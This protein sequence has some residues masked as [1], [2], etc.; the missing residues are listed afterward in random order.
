MKLTAD[1][2]IV[3]GGV[4]GCS[5][6]YNLAARGMKDLVLLERDVLGSGST[7]RSQ[8]I[9]RMHYSNA[10]TARMAWQSLDVYRNFDEIVGGPSGFVRTGYLVV[11]GPEDRKALEDNVSMQIALGIKTAVVSPADVEEIA[12]ML[13]VKDAGGLAYEPESGYADPYRVTATYARR[14]RELGAQIYMRT[15]ATEIEIT[16]GKVSAVATENG[17]TETSIAIIATGP[18]SKHVFAR[19]GMDIPLGTAR[20]QVIT[21]RRPEDAIPTHPAVGDIAQEFSFRPDSNN[22]TLIGAGE[23]D[24]DP[25]T[26]NQGVDMEVVEDTFGKLVRRMPAISRGYFRGGWSGLFTV[27]PDWHPILDR[28]EDIK[29]LY[30]AVGFSGH[31][32]KLAPMVGI[33]MAELILEGRASTVDITPLRMSRFKEGDTLRSRYRYN[34][35]A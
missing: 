32:F 15:P 24:A 2:V 35:L 20:H 11:V 31:G 22:L 14:S 27:T 12:P 29:G 9:C 1:A 5:I 33:T 34:V 4:M 26:Y 18:W 23:D 6:L 7:G 17:R 10:V 30:C 19:M 16:G 25:D 21:I 8:A 13:E 28:V 3:G